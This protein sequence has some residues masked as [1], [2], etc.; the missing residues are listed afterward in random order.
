MLTNRKASVYDQDENGQ[1]LLEV[2][3]RHD[4]ASRTLR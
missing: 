2:K 1:T 4:K 3:S